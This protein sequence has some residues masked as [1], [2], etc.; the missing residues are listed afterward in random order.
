VPLEPR[1]PL[2]RVPEAL[3]LPGISAVSRVR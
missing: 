3:E 2:R 1:R